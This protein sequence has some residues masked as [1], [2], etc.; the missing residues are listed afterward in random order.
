M[1]EELFTAITTMLLP[2]FWVL[3]YAAIVDFVLGVSLSLWQKRFDLEK[4]ANFIPND[5]FPILIWTLLSGFALFPENLVPAEWSIPGV[6]VIYGAVGLKILGSIAK[7]VAGMGVELGWIETS[8]N[9]VL[10]KI[11][12]K[13]TVK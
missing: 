12:L 9:G 1:F 8:D 11:G 7:T 10:V 3:V 2:Y 13:P 6:A 4:L 5:V